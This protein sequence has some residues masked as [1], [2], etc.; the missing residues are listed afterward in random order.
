MNK[1]IDLKM[2][3]EKKI[4][5]KYVQ[6]QINR[7]REHWRNVLLRIITVVK[8]LGKNYLAFG[9]NNEKIY[10]EANGNLLSL[11]EMIVE[12]DPIMQEHIRQ[13]K[14]DEIHN[15]YLEHN[16]QNELI[17]L[18]ASEIKK[19]KKKLEMQNIIQSYL[20]TPYI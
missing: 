15:H 11:I 13:I 6:E 7:D 5:D 10:Q 17:N 8:T 18:L 12:F 2:R 4:I 20:I 16:I 9:E 19:Y 1:W 3:L 14:D